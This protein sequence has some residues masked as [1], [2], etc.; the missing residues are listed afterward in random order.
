MNNSRLLVFGILGLAIA[1]TSSAPANAR[2]AICNKLERQLA[3]AGS[4]G[5]NAKFARAATAQAQQLQIA[6]GQARSLGCNSG[7]FTSS[8]N[9]QA[10]KR[11]NSTISK[12]Q[13]NLASLKSKAGGI[14]PAAGRSRILAAL[15]ANDCNQRDAVVQPVSAK[16]ELPKKPSKQTGLVTLL[17]GG[18]KVERRLPEPVSVDTALKK[19]RSKGSIQNIRVTNGSDGGIDYNIS[20]GNYRTLCVRTCDGYYFPVSYN[21]SNSK[22]SLDSKLCQQMCPGTEVSLYVHRVPDQEPEEM[23]SLTGEPYAKL[24]TAFK[25]RQDGLGSVAGCTCHAQTQSVDA[26]QS[27]DA[28]DLAASSL[29]DRKWIPYPAKKP[30]SMLDEE[31]RLNEAGGLDAA[32]MRYLIDAKTPQAETLA[33]QKLENQGNIRVVGPVYLPAQVQAEAGQVPDQTTVR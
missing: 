31:T 19:A 18:Q 11:I 4:T 32:A 29:A 17:F 8:A 30:S 20:Y 27:A 10:C 12:M 21:S 13:S 1:A 15:E 25:Y 28:K 3:S 6:R 22:F 7:L 33:A 5:N 26:A 23:V 24:E 9:S 14:S 16:R 2:P